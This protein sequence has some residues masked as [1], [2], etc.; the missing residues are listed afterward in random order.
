MVGTTDQAAIDSVTAKF[1]LGDLAGARADCIR[2]FAAVSDP[3]RRAPMHFWL[4]A[5]EQRGGELPAAVEQ[6]ELALQADGHNPQ[7]LMQLGTAHLLLR[8]LDRAENCYR[9]VI[10]QDARLPLAHYNLGVVLQHK[11]DLPGAQSA[12]EAALEFHPNFPEALTNLA[13]V[14]VALGVDDRAAQCYQRAVAINPG[15]T[16]AQHA[17]GLLHRRGN[18]LDAAMQCFEAAI[19]YNPEFVGAWLD[20]AE[21]LFARGNKVRALVC[22]DEALKIDPADEIARF[23]RAQYGGEQPSQI[24]HEVVARLY[25]GMAATF[26]EHLVQHLEYHTPSLLVEELNSWLQEVTACHGRGP[27]VLDLGCGTGLFGAAVRPYASTLAGVDLSAEMLAKATQR[28]IYDE[29][30]KSDFLS[31]L[32]TRGAEYELIAACDVLIYTGDLAPLFGSIAARLPANGAFA[33]SVESPRDLTV[34]Y[35]L[36]STGRYSHHPDYIRRIAAASGLDQYKFSE[37]VIRTEAGIPVRG[38][39]MVFKRKPTQ[40]ASSAIA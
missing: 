15:L 7:Y 31:H 10:R 40:R 21:L 35:R 39:L 25:A 32:K 9:K 17:L 26:D 18:R 38:C 29:L 36:E 8:D 5:I 20:L 34:D 23:K 13:N 27:S 12:F 30:V 19:E 6:F 33:F 22:I 1:K 3:A 4:G 37:S 2:F 28:G 11:K 16:N 14:L 24:P